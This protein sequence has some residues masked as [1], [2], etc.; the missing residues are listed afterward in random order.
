MV[1]YNV[2]IFSFVCFCS[3]FYF[4]KFILT[5]KLQFKIQKSLYWKLKRKINKRNKN[6]TDVRIKI[7]HV[8]LWKYLFIFIFF[9]FYSLYC[10]FVVFVFVAHFCLFLLHRLFFFLIVIFFCFCFCFF[11]YFFFYVYRLSDDCM[12]Y[13]LRRTLLFTQVYQLRRRVAS[14][15][16]CDWMCEYFFFF[17]SYR[18]VFHLT[19]GLFSILLFLSLF[20]L[21]LLLNE[22]NVKTTLKNKKQT[23]RRKTNSCIFVYV[24]V[25]LMMY[26]RSCFVCVISIWPCL[27]M[28][29]EN[30]W[31][32]C[33][34][35]W[36]QQQ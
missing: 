29:R 2:Q 28:N 35:P 27:D 23:K 33:S 32:L 1:F 10:C 18:F 6:I 7:V 12:C 8:R 15:Q 9:F 14:A 3:L 21:T 22:Q 17:I 31:V 26:L 11:F 20:S 25:N 16:K 13:C 19:L 36:T 34:V 30:I 4:N 24:R 5:K